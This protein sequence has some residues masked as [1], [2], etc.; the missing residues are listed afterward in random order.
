MRADVDQ[1]VQ[2]IRGVA[3]AGS[4]E[5][6]GKEE[7]SWAEHRDRPRFLSSRGRTS[8]RRMGRIDGSFGHPERQGN[9]R[10]GPDQG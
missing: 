4:E 7:E 3:P 10:S 2:G 5:E 6:G 1:L 8:E 9:T